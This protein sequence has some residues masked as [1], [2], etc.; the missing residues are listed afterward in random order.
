MLATIRDFLF[1]SFQEDEEDEDEEEAEVTPLPKT[2]DPAILPI[3]HEEDKLSVSIP[4][5]RL[6]KETP[7]PAAKLG[8]RAIPGDLLQRG[9]DRIAAV[10]TN[11][12]TYLL[13]DDKTTLTVNVP[14]TRKRRKDYHVAHYENLTDLLADIRETMKDD[15]FTWMDSLRMA[16]EYPL[17]FWDCM[18]HFLGQVELVDAAFNGEGERRSS[19]RRRIVIKK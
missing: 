7:H 5:K 14:K 16:S 18:F 3:F 11:N 9:L 10:R 17:F 8:D 15:G 4:K 13:S 6:R 12:V 2:N 19:R 1:P